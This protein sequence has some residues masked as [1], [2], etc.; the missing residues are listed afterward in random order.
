[1][2]RIAIT[3]LMYGWS[4]WGG[5][6]QGLVK[7]ELDEWYCQSCSEMQKKELPSYMV[8]SAT[9]EFMRVCAKCK[10]VMVRSNIRSYWKLLNYIRGDSLQT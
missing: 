9:R 10:N 5:G 1:M 3:R 7:E 8:E 2:P 6:N 4:K